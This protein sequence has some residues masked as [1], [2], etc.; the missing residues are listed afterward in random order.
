MARTDDGDALPD[1]VLLQRS[2]EG[3]RRAF[4]E[5]WRR[6]APTA[7]AYARSLGIAPLDPEDVVSDAFLSI[8]QVVRGGGG[9]DERFRPYL[10]TAVRNTWLTAARR[11]PA[12]VSIELVDDLPSDIGRIDVEAMVNSAALS[13]A[14]CSLPERWQH[15]LW[16]SEVERLPPREIADVL[17][18]R[19]NAAAALTYRAREAL[20]RAWIAAQ[21]RRA[22][23]G[24][25]HARVIELLG[26][27]AQ[28]ALGPRSQRVVAEHLASCTACRAAAGEARHLARAITL[29]PLLVGGAALVIAPAYFGAG[30]AA[31]AAGVA[32]P[33]LWPVAAAVTVAL[34]VSGGLLLRIPAEPDA[35]GV[36]MPAVALPPATAS[37]QPAP[38][39]PDPGTRTPALPP[40]P[41]PDATRP[42]V[43]SAS[44]QLPAP[45]AEVA[46]PEPAEE[47]D[48]RPE[49]DPSATPGE[50]DPTPT[51]FLTRS[52]AW[53]V[54]T[55]LTPA[56]TS[57]CP[58][59]AT[60]T[61]GGVA[62]TAILIVVDGRSSGVTATL[63]ADGSWTGDIT[64][65]ALSGRHTVT[66][67]GVGASAGFGEQI[68]ASVIDY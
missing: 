46:A 56:G 49:S 17:G 41:S 48:S 15:A 5:L 28:G 45:V 2:R 61:I 7:V 24:S 58:P 4:S 51:T 1:A 14:F 62:G 50:T 8:L 19:A 27:Y 22:P 43:D 12:T 40:A 47:P 37:A 10:L 9:P 11:A 66:I 6:H 60:V 3:D 39:T 18:L 25:E 26:G 34:A 30:Q 16:L 52:P 44:G 67:F 31:A 63:D 57:G 35:T 38:P 36:S 32:A 53:W 13:E 59:V 42:I 68:A 55:V 23:E 21:L 54:D 29:G 33:L 64:L 20:R 65:T